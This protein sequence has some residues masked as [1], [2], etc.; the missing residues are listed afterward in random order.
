MKNKQRE[1]YTDRL[2]VILSQDIDEGVGFSQING[3]GVNYVDRFRCASLNYHML[4][5][6]EISRTCT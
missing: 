5:Y 2:P 4:Y 1:R 3:G 6:Y